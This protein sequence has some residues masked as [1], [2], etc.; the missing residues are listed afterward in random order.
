MISQ[1]HSSLLASLKPTFISSLVSFDIPYLS[2]SDDFK[3]FVAHNVY[4]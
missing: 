4:Y 3:V 2:D 1:F